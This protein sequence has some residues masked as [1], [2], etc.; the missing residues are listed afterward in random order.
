MFTEQV[1]QY[2]GVFATQE[3]INA[4]K[5]DYKAIVNTLRPGDMKYKDFNGDGKITPDDRV[6]TDF[7]NIPTFQGGLSVIA[8]YGA[9]DLNILFQGSAGAKQYVS[10]GE[11]GNIGNY[12]LSM[13]TDRWTVQNPSSIHPRIANRSDQYFSGG[14]DYWF[15]NTDYIR[16][17]NVEIG[18]ALPEKIV[19]K[20]GITSFRVYLNGL[21]LFTISDFDAFD[22]ESSSATGQFYPQQR[23][24]NGGLTVTF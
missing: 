14:N 24:I 4:E 2:D 18:Y 19:K 10:P 20:A 16:L 17:K 5:L 3:E 1:Y 13:Y 15:R 8:S 6:R 22:P 11:M 12:L 9:F 7:N 21:N 23:V